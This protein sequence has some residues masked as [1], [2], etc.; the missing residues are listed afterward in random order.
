[1]KTIDSI[2]SFD[3]KSKES[4]FDQLRKPKTKTFWQKVGDLLGHHDQV[5]H[6]FGNFKDGENK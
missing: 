3:T 5:S 4:I 2:I 1:M 6:F